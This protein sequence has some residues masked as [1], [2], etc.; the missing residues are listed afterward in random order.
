MITD[1]DRL[2]VEVLAVLNEKHWTYYRLAELPE[3]KGARLAKRLTDKFQ[4]YF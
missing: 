3:W 2:E 1:E 4:V